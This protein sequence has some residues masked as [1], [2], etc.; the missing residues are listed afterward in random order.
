VHAPTE[1]KIDGSNDIFYEELEQV[2]HHFPKCFMKILVGDLNAKSGKKSIFKNQLGMRVCIRVKSNGIR[3]L[4][5]ATS[6]KSIC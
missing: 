4:N 2:F 6:K 5:F 1:E 3:T